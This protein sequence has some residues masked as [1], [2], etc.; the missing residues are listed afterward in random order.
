MTGPT[1]TI[2]TERGKQIMVSAKREGFWVQQDDG[3]WQLMLGHKAC[4]ADEVEAMERA[5]IRSEGA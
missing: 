3:T 4:G 5:A 2:T 1:R